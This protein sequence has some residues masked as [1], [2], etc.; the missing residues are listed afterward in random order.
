MDHG[1]AIVDGG[2]SVEGTSGLL[3]HVKLKAELELFDS[4]GSL[5]PT[6][7]LSLSERDEEDEDVESEAQLE[8]HSLKR[9]IEE[10][11]EHR[12]R[13]IQE[14]QIKVDAAEKSKRKIRRLEQEVLELRKPTITKL[15]E[16]F[17]ARAKLAKAATYGFLDKVVGR[18]PPQAEVLVNLY[19]RRSGRFTRV[20][21]E[22]ER[23][24]I[25][26]YVRAPGDVPETPLIPNAS[27][28]RG[29]GRGRGRGRGRGAVTAPIPVQ[30]AHGS[31]GSHRGRGR[32]RGRGRAANTITREELADEIARAIRDT[33][34]D[35]V[36]QAREAIMGEYEGNLGG[37]EEDYE[38]STPNMSCEPSIA[39]P[40]RH[41][42]NHDWRGCSYKTFMNC[43]PPIFNG[44]INPIFSSTW[45]MEIEGTF[46]T[47]KCADEDKVIYAATMLKG[48]AIHWWGMLEE[49]FLRLEQ[50]NM[51]VREYTTK[52]TEKARFVEF[53]VSTEE[54]R[55][56]RYIWGLRTDIREFV[57]IQKPGT[58][59]SA[60]DAA[61]GREREKNRQGQERKVDQSSGVKQCPKCNR[62]HKGECNMN[63]KVC[64]KC[65]KPGH[66]ATECKTR[67]VCYGCGSPNHIKS[68]CPQSKGNN[69]QGMITDNRSMDKKVDSGRPKARAFRMTAQEAQETPDVVTGV[70]PIARAPYRLAPT[71]MKELM[72]Q[73]QDLLDKG[74]LRPSTS[75]RGAPVLFVKKKDG[76]MRMCI[77]YK[78]LNK[79]DP[80][81]IEA[82][83]KW[84]PPR[85]PSEVQSFLGLAGYYRRFIQDFS[86]IVAPLTTLTRKN[87]KFEWKPKQ[88]NAF[89]V[90]KE[91]LSSAPVLSLPEGNDDFVVYSDASKL[92]LGCVL[93]Q[94]SK[95]IA[96]ASQQLKVHER[97]Y[98]THDMEL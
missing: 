38:Y 55:V 73:L 75:L 95:V 64:Y 54:R 40:T 18:E 41:H 43:K 71:E 10:I 11:D 61:E 53:Y 26:A 86:R 13:L 94:N 39:Q 29:Q 23:I 48:E 4:E 6:T 50:G 31:S 8:I 15:W 36:A 16:G 42:G 17:V 87:V 32:G 1:K 68:E 57:Q 79:V 65:G 72:A 83:E 85:T 63:Q 2:V 7:P 47:S 96:Y 45:I 12:S 33:L 93:M 88:D 35:V 70:A 92:G 21:P 56:E 81:K 60:V 5:E 9:K 20:T 62:Y 52:F 19:S 84:E 27:R 82:I 67:R 80:A 66:I 89:N 44:E 14:N 76:T 78:E 97:K 49:E 25:G 58:F 28:G 90:L 51:T 30:S 22:E 46:D 69:N 24:P 3:P 98:P 37:G 34:P 91:K 59:Q 77:D 74:F